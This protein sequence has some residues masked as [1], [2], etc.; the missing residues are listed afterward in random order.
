MVLSWIEENIKWCDPIPQDQDDVLWFNEEDVE[1]EEHDFPEILEVNDEIK[2]AIPPKGTGTWKN[3]FS[4]MKYALI[5]S[6]QH[7]PSKDLGTSEEITE[8][9]RALS[10]AQKPPSMRLPQNTSQTIKPHAP[11]EQ[12]CSEHFEST[13]CC[14]AR[15]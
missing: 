7:E 14:E 5:F 12:I 3:G 11:K 2:L 10:Q 6:K 4:T 15:R 1:E 13:K 9:E 8:L